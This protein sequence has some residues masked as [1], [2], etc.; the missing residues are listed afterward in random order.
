MKKG[1]VNF[2]TLKSAANTG[3]KRKRSR[4][5]YGQNELQR[6]DAYQM[7]F[8][9]KEVTQV[10]RQQEIASLQHSNKPVITNTVL[11][12]A[13]EVVYP[14]CVPSADVNFVHTHAQ[15]VK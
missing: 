8:D 6:G 7:T 13:S 11:F 10:S 12:P 4:S 9:K 5:T 1:K 15:L 2:F 14:D 3:T